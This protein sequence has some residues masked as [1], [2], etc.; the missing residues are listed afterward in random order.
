MRN[1]PTH[2]IRSTFRTLKPLFKGDMAEQGRRLMKMIG[3]AVANL[4]KLETIVP[5]VGDLGDDMQP[6]ASS[7]RIT[8]LSQ[9]RCS[10]RSGKDWAVLSR[11]RWSARPPT[12]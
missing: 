9:P 4:D 2:R 11:R 12:D 6:M 1:E 10:G 5:A 8:T 7:R 3:T